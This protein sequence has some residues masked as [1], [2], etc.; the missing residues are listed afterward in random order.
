MPKTYAEQVADTLRRDLERGRWTGTMPGRD[1]LAREFDANARTV[2]R[3]L[4]LLEKDGVLESQGVGRRRKI[5]LKAGRERVQE[6]KMILYERGNESLG[7]ILELRRQLEAAG[8]R[9]SFTSKTLTELKQDPGRVAKLVAAEPSRAWIILAGSR[10]VLEWFAE[11]GTPC[12]AFF[13]SMTDLAIAGAGPEKLKALREAIQ[14]LFDRGHRKIVMISREERRGDKQG[15]VERVFLDELERREI[16]TGSYNQPDWEGTAMGLH[17]CL[18][19]AFR[20]TPPTAI[21]VD[22]QS[23]L[24]AVK[25][26]LAAHRGAALRQVALICTDKDPSFDWCEPPIPH[27]TWDEQ[28]VVRRAVRWARNI[29][30]GKKDLRQ[31]LTP[32]TLV[33]AGSIP[34]LQT[35]C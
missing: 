23:L 25:N 29:A 31:Q 17:Q 12:F 5:M 26:H 24:L 19:S 9:L 15:M 8:H 16:R 21:F 35:S 22:D 4:A 33:G 27:L 28:A 14:L 34:V 30:L 18:E 6:L 3:A 7:Y 11:S 13:G 2:D 1:R 20:L 10:S 32:A